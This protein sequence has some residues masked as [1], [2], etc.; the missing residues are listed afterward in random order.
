[1]A[2]TKFLPFLCQRA[3]ILQGEIIQGHEVS[4]RYL[5]PPP[6]PNTHTRTSRNEYVPPFFKVVGITS[7]AKLQPTKA[8]PPPDASSS[9]IECASHVR[10]QH[11]TPTK[12]STSLNT[13]DVPRVMVPND[14]EPL[15]L[16]QRVPGVNMCADSNTTDNC[17][18]TKMDERQMRADSNVVDDI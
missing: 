8:P 14:Q 10:V 9:E 13:D 16:T 17:L 5:E 4:K 7:L 11:G 1:M 15:T 6:P 12:K 2:F 3:V 18:A